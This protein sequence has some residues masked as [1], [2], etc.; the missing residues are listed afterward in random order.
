M[1]WFGIDFLK[2]I[3]FQPPA[4]GWDIF[5]LIRLLC[6]YDWEKFS[7]YEVINQLSSIELKNPAFIFLIICSEILVTLTEVV[8]E[9]FLILPCWGIVIIFLCYVIF[10][11]CVSPAV[12]PC[13][14]DNGGCSHI[15]IAKGDGT[16][17]CSCPEHLVLLQ[18]LLTCGGEL[19]LT[20]PLINL[21]QKRGSWG[22]IPT[23][24]VHVVLHPVLN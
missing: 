10:F 3:Q 22:C 5:N 7:P 13:S 6:Y 23:Q 14:R 24:N 9:P 8:C 2:V 12:H 18:N 16:P 21:Y 4:M 11:L 1:I 17:R 19:C 20:A 15:C